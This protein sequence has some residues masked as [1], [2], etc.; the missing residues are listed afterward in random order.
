MVVAFFSISQSKLP[1]YVLTA[2]VALGILT[3]RLFDRALAA[4]RGRAGRVVRRGAAILAGMSVVLGAWLA[5]EVFA[6]GVLASL[7]H[8][9]SA[10][11]ERARAVFPP[12]PHHGG[13][14]RLGPGGLL[15]PAGWAS[16]SSPSW[17]S[18][19]PW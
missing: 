1:G 7:F 15:H 5:M 14:G 8:I 10:D 18:P 2:V 12:P 6:P 4:P 19:S 16:C 11:Y 9:R 13:A 17:C 3:A